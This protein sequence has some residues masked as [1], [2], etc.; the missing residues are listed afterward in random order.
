VSRLLVVDPSVAYPEDDGVATVLRGWP[1]EAAVLQPALRPGD[2]PAPGSSYEVAGVVVL[3]SRASV[4]DDVPWLRG[5]GA[6]LD[7][8][9]AGAVR[10]PLFGICFGHQLV[11]HRAGG[12]VGPLAGGRELGLRETLL[13]GGRLLPGRRSLRV[14]ASHAEEVKRLPFGYRAVASRE[15]VPVDGL[16]HDRLPIFGFQFHPEAR[17]SF[18]AARG[19]DPAAIGAAAED[20]DRLIAAFH[21]LALEAS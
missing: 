13:Q 8:I 7:P 17:G 6:W 21:R 3:G 14:V 5:L 15:R 10:V 18:L 4:H 19:L 20:G 2:G 9:L 12:V 1:G 11:A 16:E